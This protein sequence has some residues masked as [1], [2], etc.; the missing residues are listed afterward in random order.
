M[1]HPGDDSGHAV[2]ITYMSD[3][4]NPGLIQKT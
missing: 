1:Q 4:M 2:L 3:R